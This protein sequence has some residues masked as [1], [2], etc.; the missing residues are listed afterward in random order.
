MTNLTDQAEPATRS[1]MIVE[2]QTTIRQLLAVFIANVPG[3]RVVGEAGSA[4]E[5]LECLARVKPDVLILDWMLH[6]STGGDVLQALPAE[7]RPHVL[8][9]SADTGVQMVRDAMA[10]GATG[11]IEKTASFERFTEA[12]QAVAKGDSYFGSSVAR[13]MRQI[14]TGMQPAAISSRERAV[15]RL[16]A[17][18]HSTRQIAEQ[19]GLSTRTVENHRANI[20]R[21]T[22][23]RSVAQFTLLAARLGLIA[24]VQAAGPAY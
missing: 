2:D 21:R 20:S 9:F 3:F 12:L 23:I 24:T 4:D 15:L 11:L 16:V 10:A 1:V 6:G 22:G 13:T 19:L 5:A 8:V 17:E 7:D 18:G 14:V